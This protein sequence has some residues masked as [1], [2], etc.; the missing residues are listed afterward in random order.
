MAISD[1]T[2]QGLQGRSQL[3]NR[4]DVVPFA[5]I[6]PV[7]SCFDCAVHPIEAIVAA[8]CGCE[9]RRLTRPPFRIRGKGLACFTWNMESRL[10]GIGLERK[11][12]DGA[13]SLH[14]RRWIRLWITLGIS[15]WT[16]QVQSLAIR[17][18]FNV[19]VR[20]REAAAP[21]CRGICFT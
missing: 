20:V 2:E 19:S 10:D 6:R 7:V 4:S 3:R 13:V 17:R 9:L 1:D 16:S 15:L 12:R 8:S 5:A 14:T 18:R 21:C 11:A